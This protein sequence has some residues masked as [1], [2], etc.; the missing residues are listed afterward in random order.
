MHVIDPRAT[1]CAVAEALAQTPEEPRSGE[2][3]PLF[4]SSTPIELPLDQILGRAG[5]PEKKTSRLTARE[6]IRVHAA[7]EQGKPS[8]I[9]LRGEVSAGDVRAQFQENVAKSFA[10][11]SLG[12]LAIP[13]AIRVGRKE[14][15]MHVAIALG[16]SLAYYFALVI[17]GMARESLGGGAATL[18]WLPNGLFQVLG[19]VLIFRLMRS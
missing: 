19:I 5:E 10:P 6:L 13:L 7:L 12:L 15:Y 18:M 4:V 16:L 2:R 8:P 9:P 14:T 17:M 3:A 11:L 1:L